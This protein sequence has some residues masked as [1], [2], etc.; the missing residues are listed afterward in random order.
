M[1][2]VWFDRSV[3]IPVDDI[4]KEYAPHAMVFQG[5]QAT[6]RWVGN[7]GGYAPYPAWNAVDG[8]DPTVQAGHSTARHG[9]PDGD[10]WLPNE[11]D[12]TIRTHYWFWNSQSVDDIKTL[13][14]LM[15]LYHRSVGHGGVFLLNANPNRSGLIPKADMK[16][17]AEFGAEITRR[18]G[19]SIAETTGRGEGVQLSLSQPTAVD[20]VITMEDFL[21]GERV[22]E[23]LVEAPVGGKWKTIAEG[24]A[25]GHKKIDRFEPVKVSMIRLRIIKAAATPLIR[26]LAVYSTAVSNRGY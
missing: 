26:K 8:N 5:P 24:T 14:H 17:Y 20:H 4:L 18:F 6:I 9:D 21:E 11:C 12:T 1:V 3:T 2:E 13:D 23:Y 15:D 19:K 22:R 7:E 16:R 10:R 25:I